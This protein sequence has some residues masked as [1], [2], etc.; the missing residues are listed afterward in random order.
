MLRT[1]H[2]QRSRHGLLK[3]GE[4]PPEYAIWKAMIQKCFNERCAEYKSY[5]ARGVTV[6]PRWLDDDG[7]AKFLSDVGPQ[8]FP[9][10]GLR[11]L[12]R[13]GNFEPGNV[14]WGRTR[15]KHV[16]TY[17]GRS[18]SLREWAK[19]L[20][21]KERTLRARLRSGWSPKAMLTRPP[22]CR[23]HLDWYRSRKRKQRDLGCANA[24]S[25]G[26]VTE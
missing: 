17:E 9:G 26:T 6:C 13:D 23:D 12:N 14:E 20:G 11:R 2:A 8:L 5:G 22:A 16:I 18:M 15:T 25:D 3:N 7:F 4:R 21:V 1:K 24:Q 10:A 19:E